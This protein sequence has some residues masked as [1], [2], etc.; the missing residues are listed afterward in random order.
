MS[1]NKMSAVIDLIKEHET[2]IGH[3]SKAPRMYAKITPQKNGEFSYDIYACANRRKDDELIIKNVFSVNSN[4]I[5]FKCRDIVYIDNFC[6]LFKPHWAVDY[7]ESRRGRRYMDMMNKEYGQWDVFFAGHKEWKDVFIPTAYLLNDFDGTKYKYCGYRYDSGMNICKYLYF[8]R[9][10]P[11]IE[12]LSKTGL[13]KLMT[14]DAL[15]VIDNNKQLCKWL[16]KHINEARS[17]SWKLNQLLF[18]YNKDVR[19]NDYK[20]IMN[21]LK[22]QKKEA[23]KRAEMRAIRRR[24]I[25]LRRFDKQILALYERIK[26]ICGR[27][28]CYDVY[29]PQ[30]SSEIVDEGKAMHNCLSNH[31]KGTE[32]LVFL[33][34]EGKPYIDMSISLQTFKVTE[35]RMV[36]NALCK[37]DD[38]ILADEIAHKIEILYKA[39]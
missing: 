3:V 27:H 39:A 28:G 16:S 13:F 20:R 22:I 4:G 37:D 15:K 1:S 2:F 6:K 35:C 26:D 9:K 34:K 33:R 23:E 11:K 7:R 31:A 5:K 18:H 30:K 19:N 14:E 36:C 25:E 12:L 8:W 21:E 29:V 24:K 17:K 32:I 38:R 10:Y